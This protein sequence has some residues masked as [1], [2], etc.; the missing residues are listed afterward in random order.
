MATK[1]RTGRRP[2][3]RNPPQHFEV[4]WDETSSYSPMTLDARSL[5]LP[6][7]AIIGLVGAFMWGTWV[8][9]NT[10]F[11]RDQKL[12]NTIRAVEQLATSVKTIAEALAERSQH[13]WTYE[14]QTTFCWQAEAVNKDWKCPD[15]RKLHG[16]SD[17]RLKDAARRA[18][19][20][21]DK[22]IPRE[23]T[24]GY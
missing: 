2:V 10:Q 7:L 18:G 13:G 4:T 17:S 14:E 22:W 3:K 20:T 11:H 8:Y 19:N 21:V 23:R 16:T 9:L 15:L 6:S 5:T 24:Y 1:A 12:E